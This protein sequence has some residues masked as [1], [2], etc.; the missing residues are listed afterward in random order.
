MIRLIA[1]KELRGLLHAPSTW[2]ILAALQL[3]LALFYLGALNSF[4]EHQAELALTPNAAGATQK[5]VPYFFNIV[6]LLLLILTPVF[7]MWALA[8]ERRNQTLPLLLSAPVSSTQI[9]LGKF[10]G[11]LVFL[12][13]IVLCSAAMT[14]TL[15]VGTAMDFGLVL[16]N[17][18]GLLLLTACYAALGLYFS[19][20]TAQPIV[21]AVSSLAILF[22]MWLAEAG[23]S[24]N[25]PVWRTLTPT[26][27]FHN[28]NAGLL[29]STDAIYYL[30]FTAFFLTL[31]IRRLDNTRVYG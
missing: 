29:G 13:L 18:L 8:E 5:V 2:Y 20:L 27:H 23:A 30:L 10:T 11:V 25:Y 22:P 9:V 15:K 4:L 6:A 12:W 1:L 14:L 16:G 17:T 19:S 31:A 28:F 7:T 21:A 3:V 24:A 26:G